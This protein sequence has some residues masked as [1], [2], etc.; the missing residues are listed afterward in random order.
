M[1]FLIK[2]YTIKGESASVSM[3]V[4][5][6]CRAEIKKFIIS[7]APKYGL[8]NIWNLDETALFYRLMPNRTLACA[9]QAGLKI[10]KKAYNR[11]NYMQCIGK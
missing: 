6:E 8:E 10:D 4:V 9:P 7:F 5:E 1:H 3:K 11:S 2:Q